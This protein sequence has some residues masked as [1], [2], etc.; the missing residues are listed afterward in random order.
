MVDFI[1]LMSKFYVRADDRETLRISLTDDT[2]IS[3]IDPILAMHIW[4]LVSNSITHGSATD[5][6]ISVVNKKYVNESNYLEITVA[7]NGTGFNESVLD[8][9]GSEKAKTGIGGKG[10]E[11]LRDYLSRV[12]GFFQIISYEGSGKTA[13]KL[14]I[15]HG[16]TDCI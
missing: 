4:E 9:I 5:I 7:D 14:Y 12:N 2:D 6:K 11:L 3:E 1:R 8:A 16:G 13:V 10:W 15:P